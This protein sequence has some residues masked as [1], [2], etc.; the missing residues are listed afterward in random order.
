M[1]DKPKRPEAQDEPQPEDRP[2]QPDDGNGFGVRLPTMPSFRRGAGAGIEHHELSLVSG[3][4]QKVFVTCIDYSPDKVHV[5]DVV[6]VQDFL[7]QHRPEWSAVRWIDIDGISDPSIVRAFAEKYD[8]HPLAV[9]DVM[10]VPQRPK[11]EDYPSTNEHQARLFVIARMLRLLGTRLYCE[12]VSMFLGRSTLITFQ[13]VKGDVWDS[14]RQRIET[15][16]SRIRKNDASFLLYSLLDAA[17]DQCFPILEHFSDRLETLEDAVLLSPSRKTIEQVHTI[18]RE[19]LLLRRAAWPM[20]DAIHSLQREP[21]ECLSDTT[22]TYL[23][24]V[25]DHSIQIIDLIETY[26]EFAASLTDTYLSSMSQRMNEVMKVLTIMGTIFIPLSFLA[27]VYGMNMPIPENQ[28][29]WM[30]PTFWG[31]CIATALGMVI[32]FKKR[33]WM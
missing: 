28:F 2:S 17:V 8:L 29:S 19:L 6:D 14:V 13:E 27:A 25:Y 22:R 12:Q 3:G 23:R 11:A 10:H 24:D 26:R 15:A 5:Q 7:N 20:R 16:G 1:T 9:E 33:G 32:W 18:K 31:I 21:H 4:E 30:Y